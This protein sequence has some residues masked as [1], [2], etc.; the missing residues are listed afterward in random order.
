MGTKHLKKYQSREACKCTIPTQ[1][2]IH[3]LLRR[4]LNRRHKIYPTVSNCKQCMTVRTYRSSLTKTSK[5]LNTLQPSSLLL[6]FNITFLP[7][8]LP[9]CW[10]ARVKWMKSEGEP[11]GEPNHRLGFLRSQCAD[12]LEFHLVIQPVWELLLMI[13]RESGCSFLDIS[14]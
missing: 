14:V 13:D 2:I 12:I 4:A 7:N 11:P 5:Y 9:V 6:D 3:V 8:V 10:R 1:I